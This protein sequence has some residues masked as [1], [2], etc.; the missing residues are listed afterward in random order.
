MYADSVY[1]IVERCVVSA[2]RL[3][4][5]GQCQILVSYIIIYHIGS[6]L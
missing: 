2:H 4:F 3:D 6:L 1:I 5:G